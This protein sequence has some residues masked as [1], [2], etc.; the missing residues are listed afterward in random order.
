MSVPLD[1]TFHG[2]D[3]SEAV[4]TRVREKFAKLE[5]YFDRITSARVVIEAAQRNSEKVKVVGVK[6]EV[7]VPGRKPLIVSHEREAA[8]AH[9]DVL[10]ALRDAFDIAQRQ[11]DATARKIGERTRSERGRRRPRAAVEE[12]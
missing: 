7:G 8:H 9:D 10:L 1:I 2:L 11:I 6:I 4:E 5:R 12:S 3:R